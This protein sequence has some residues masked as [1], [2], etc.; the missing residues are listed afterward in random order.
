MRVTDALSRHAATRPDVLAVADGALRF[1]W[2]ELAREVDMAAIHLRQ[3]G[4]LEGDRVALQAADGGAALVAA[5]AV[6]QAGGVHAPIDHA[7]TTPEVAAAETAVAAHWR[8]RLERAAPVRALRLEATGHPR[9]GDPLGS[10]SSAFVRCSSGTTGLAKG[11]LLSHATIAARIAAANSGL[12]LTADDRVL[13]LLPMAYH[14]AVSILLYLEVGAAVVFGNSL[15]ASTTAATA[16]EHGVTFLYGSPWHIR[17]LAELTAGHD[18]PATL[19]QVVS[20]TTALDADAAT[21]FRTR[22]GIGVRQAFGIIEVGLP[23]V[24]AGRVDEPVGRFAVQPAYQVAA[25]SPAGEVVSRGVAGELAIAGPG[26]LDA[27]LSPWKAREQLLQRGWFCT[28]DVARV[29]DDGE[30]QLLGR[31]KDVI[32]VGGVKVF[33]LEVEAVLAAHPAVIACRVRGAP[34]SRSGEQVVAE[35]QVRD[36]TDANAL[37]AWCAERLAPLKRPAVIT[38]LS[39]LPMTPSGK[40]RR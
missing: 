19:R 32:N 30:V 8:I 4:L 37:A 21:L 15:R 36:A 3:Q 40:V 16:R 23:L 22:H 39:A 10:G 20:T 18:L 29:E 38:L 13:W 31:I 34:D 9:V 35:A 5:L 1:T 6:M 17:R 24:S 25:L 7:L 33:P 27:Y 11:I 26:M 12:R 14:F 28:G 2:S